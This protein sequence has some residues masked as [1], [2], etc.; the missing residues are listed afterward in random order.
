M[1]VTIPTYAISVSFMGRE[2]RR[3][4]AERERRVEEL[5]K[6]VVELGSRLKTD[7]GLVAL[8]NEI[9]G[10]KK[11][12]KKIRGRVDSLS[13][14]YACFL[15]FF[16]FA[17][18]L[19]VA[20]WGFLVFNGS[21]P[22]LSGLTVSLTYLYL[23]V[24]SILWSILGTLFLSNTLVQVNR[25]ATKPQTLSA[26]RLSFASGSTTE[27]FPTHQNKVVYFVLNNFG[28]EMGENVRADIYFPDNFGVSEA[29]STAS[30]ALAAII[31]RQP[32]HSVI[33]YPNRL[34]ASVK[35]DDIHE[36]MAASIAV[37]LTMPSSVG[38]YKVPAHIWERRLG[39]SVQELTFE[40]TP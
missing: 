11:D 34:T 12:V 13:V 39:K 16:C 32:T 28:K 22:Q 9:N 17:L 36:D 19:V 40:I 4:I 35:I 6:K 2:R 10:Y 21:L 33:T 31:H 23:A 26:L 27:K 25:A 24:F 20:A 8:E 29:S 1:S 30:N 3:A 37:D 15:P 38:T 14:Y 5:E 7:P 18:S